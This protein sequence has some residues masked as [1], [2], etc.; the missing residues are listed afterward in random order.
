MQSLPPELV[1]LIFTHYV[2]LDRPR[3]GS[4]SR[5]RTGP[6]LL[7]T[8]CSSWRALVL[9]LPELW[10]TLRIYPLINLVFQR[11]LDL[12][13]LWLPRAGNALL[14]IYVSN[15][16]NRS[17][18]ESILSILSLFSARIRTLDLALREFVQIP[19]TFKCDKL[20]SLSLEFLVPRGEEGRITPPTAFHDAGLLRLLTLSYATLKS[21]THIPLKQITHLEFLSSSAYSCLEVLKRTPQVEELT[22]DL[23][24]DRDLLSPPPLLTLSRLH[25][26]RLMN[27]ADR[28]L[29]PYLVLPELN[30]LEVNGLQSDAVLRVVALSERSSWS[31]RSIR[32]RHMKCGRILQTLQANPSLESLEID[33]PL[34]SLIGLFEYM[35]KDASFVP[36][37]RKLV[38]ENYRPAKD[39]MVSLAAA[40]VAKGPATS[41]TMLLVRKVDIRW[42]EES[43]HG[44][45]QT[46]MADFR[47]VVK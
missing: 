8:V 46:P 30:I 15:A 18:T 12:L 32:L 28:T 47:I 34:D 13:Q 10:S 27:N 16:F 42:V 41:V 11:T 24:W 40:I 3:I 31:L 19:D 9:V 45:L 7:A 44:A 14:D 33:W 38:I 23:E 21:V 1:S 35:A 29:L 37:L 20:E 4:A 17:H 43:L 25:I 6:L 5:L 2:V 26:L 22:A 36:D 39:E